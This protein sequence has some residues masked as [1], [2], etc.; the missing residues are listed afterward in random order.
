MPLFMLGVGNRRRILAVHGDDAVRKHLGE[1]GFV[2]G[3]E[4]EIISE[5]GGNVIVAVYGSRLALNRDLA[6]RI[7]V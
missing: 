4:V 6:R 7:M 3:A 2:E 1:L 5:S